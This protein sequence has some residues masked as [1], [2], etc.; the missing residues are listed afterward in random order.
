MSRVKSSTIVCYEF[1]KC[2]KCKNLLAYT[3]FSRRVTK[4]GQLHEKC[5]ACA[6][7]YRLN[8]IATILGLAERLRE[9][10]RKQT[11]EYRQ[12]WRRA[13]KKLV[14]SYARKYQANKLKRTPAWAD[15]EAIELF[16]LNCP[17]GYEVDHIIPLQGKKVSGLHVLDNL[18][19]LTMYENRSKGNKF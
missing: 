18:Q 19:Y 12:A 2:T 1:K 16:Y 4:T 17:D 15:L 11:K 6:A 14:T 13:N 10:S 8:R 3:A 5:R 9:L 7:A